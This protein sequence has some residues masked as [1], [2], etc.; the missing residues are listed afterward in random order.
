MWT[1]VWQLISNSPHSWNVIMKPFW[2][3]KIWF[4]F[5]SLRI[6]QTEKTDFFSSF[7]NC[8]Y[9]SHSFLEL[10]ISTKSQDTYYFL[11]LWYLHSSRDKGNE[12]ENWGRK[13]REENRGMREERQWDVQIFHFSIFQ[14]KYDINEIYEWERYSIVV[15]TEQWKEKRNQW[16]KGT[17]DVDQHVIYEGRGG[18]KVKSYE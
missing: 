6:T 15:V 2:H 13:K 5:L 8:R 18:K 1:L 16:I 14:G 12:G 4:L 7:L 3:Q 17:S 11:G 10:V 9:K